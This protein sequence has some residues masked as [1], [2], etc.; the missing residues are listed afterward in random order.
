MC[1]TTGPTVYFSV[2]IA[3]PQQHSD[4]NSPEEVGVF[5]LRDSRHLGHVA[6]LDLVHWRD[7]G[8]VG[9]QIQGHYRECRRA[10]AHR[11]LQ[12]EDL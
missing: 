4:L 10:R 3:A 9:G 1:H 12:R 2:P 7:V 6:D 11:R 5:R 8:V